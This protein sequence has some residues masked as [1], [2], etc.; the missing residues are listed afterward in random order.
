MITTLSA[1]AALVLSVLLPTFPEGLT[2]AIVAFL[3]LIA[4][5]GVGGALRA[6]AARA[7]LSLLAPWVLALALGLINGA[8]RG[9]ESVQFAE[10]ALPYLLFAL[11]LCAGRGA[12]RP[13]WL[14]VAVVAVAIFDGVA[15]IAR[16][17]SFDL[18]NVRSTYNYF[19]VIVGHLLV[20]VFVA[21]FLFEEARRR[22]RAPSPWT[23][24]LVEAILVVSVIVTVS[25]GMVL[26]LALGVLVTF[27]LRRPARGVSLAL[28]MGLV[29]LLFAPALWDFGEAYLR[30]GTLSTVHGRM[31]EIVHCLQVFARNPLFGAGLG[32]EFIVD[33]HVV[34]YVH[35][36]VAYHL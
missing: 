19:K 12:A 1:L 28:A 16:M 32:A 27:V 22:R 29:A 31:R 35:N 10:D 6:R 24:W 14:L 8:L 11:G 20:A 26:S 21:A 30:F 34:S 7:E 23:L 17:P 36:M 13:R 5:A 18:P 15:S 9:H 33:A 3:G 4:L 25:R 2:P